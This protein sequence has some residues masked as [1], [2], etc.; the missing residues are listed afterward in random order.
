MVM[1]SLAS[2]VLGA[3]LLVGVAEASET[4]AYAYR[5]Q[6]LFQSGKYHDAMRILQSGLLQSAKEADLEGES[7]IYM[8]MAQILFYG[9]EFD[10]AKLLLSKVRESELNSTARLSL[11]RLRMQIANHLAEY[12]ES[13]A[14]LEQ[15]RKLLDKDDISEP[16]KA[17]VLLEDCV[18]EAGLGKSCSGEEWEEVEDLLDDEAPGTI[19]FAKARAADLSKNMDK[20]RKHYAA[21]LE[22][23]Q[24]RQKSWEAGQI[25]I[26][27]AQIELGS[28]KQEVA[29]DYFLRAAKL[30][31]E[32]MLDRP[33]L[34]A[35]E[36][37][38]ALGKDDREIGM[39][40]GSAKARLNP[41][42]STS[43]K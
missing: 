26:R 37:Y 6:K 41:V 13:K 3:T 33:F 32:L 5:A 16:G 25:L 43:G 19:E 20:A 40:V 39:A 4:G 7:R 22:H 1:R 24:K 18:A 21:A 30:Y 27:L 17:R 36:A 38:L 35:A 12:S 9:Y 11:L 2:M 10:G 42:D 14:M 31:H 15:N 29:G 8:G 23:A 28:G 34:Q